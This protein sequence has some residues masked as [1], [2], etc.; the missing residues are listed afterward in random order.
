VSDELL[1]RELQPTD[2]AAWQRLWDGYNVFYGRTGAAAL[3]PEV[4]EMT[5]SRFFDRYEPVHALVAE[6]AGALIGLT[7]YVLHRSTIQ[8][9]PVCYLEDLYTLESARGQGVASALIEAVYA[10]ARAAGIRG[11]YWQTHESNAVARRLYDKIA[12]RLGF[13]VYDKAL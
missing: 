5:W 10:V 8:L 13:I 2:R 7:H 12:T 9:M 11:V 1:V 3:A 4:T 6:R